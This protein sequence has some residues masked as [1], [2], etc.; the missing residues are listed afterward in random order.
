LTNCGDA[1]LRA[2]LPPLDGL[3]DVERLRPHGF[4][5]ECPRSDPLK[6]TLIACRRL[7]RGSLKPDGGLRELEQQPIN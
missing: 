3:Y 4:E 1:F 2:D 7:R 6:V 5:C